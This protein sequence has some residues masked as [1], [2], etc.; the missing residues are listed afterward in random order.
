MRHL[1]FSLLTLLI[2]ALSGCGKDSQ[3][4]NHSTGAGLQGPNAFACTLD[5]RFGLSIDVE[6]PAGASAQDLEVRVRNVASGE[7]SLHQGSA[8]GTQ[9]FVDAGE[10]PGTYDIVASL[11]GHA[12]VSALGVVLLSDGCHVVHQNIALSIQ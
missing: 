6:L 5:F 1:S 2:L 3:N 12:D 8:N 7:V 4:G 11:P 9:R 10:A